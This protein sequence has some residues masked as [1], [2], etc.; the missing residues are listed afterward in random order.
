MGMEVLVL[1]VF[2]PE[3]PSLIPAVLFTLSIC[4]ALG[5]QWAD[6]T[7]I[8]PQANFFENLT[9]KETVYEKNLDVV[10]NRFAFLGERRV[11]ASPD[12]RRD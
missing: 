5:I 11:V 9:V 2:L 4:R 1:L 3:F 10:L 6:N 8:G 12:D 7:A